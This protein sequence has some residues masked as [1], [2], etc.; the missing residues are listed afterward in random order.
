MGSMPLA[1]MNRALERAGPGSL[2]EIE[3]VGHE[4]GR[5]GQEDQV[6]LGR[7]EEPGP[8]E[9]VDELA[10]GLERAEGR[11]ASDLHLARAAT[12]EGDRV[13]LIV[14]RDDE[15][16]AHDFPGVGPTVAG[17][18]GDALLP[19]KAREPDVDRGFAGVGLGFR[20]ADQ[21]DALGGERAPH[22]LAGLR[23]RVPD[24]VAGELLGQHDLVGAPARGGQQ[25]LA[26]LHRHRRAQQDRGGQAQRKPTAHE[27]HPMW[28]RAIGPAKRHRTQPSLRHCRYQGFL[29]QKSVMAL[30][31]CH[32]P[33]RPPG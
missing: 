10:D 1:V 14:A 29:G 13:H 7:R 19:G 33:D 8:A 26:G 12:I 4:D 28:G 16:F 9:A 15:V 11:A 32:L 18:E 22:Q 2:A 25:Q 3:V 30:R 6:A 20:H 5:G 23:D 24:R 17:R 31:Y 27:T 21:L